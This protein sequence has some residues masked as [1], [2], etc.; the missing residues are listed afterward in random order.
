MGIEATGSYSVA[1][2]KT[3]ETGSFLNGLRVIELADELGEYCG[4]VLAGLGADVIKL[5]PLGGEKTRSYGPFYNDEPHPNRSLHFW[6]YNFGKRSIVI[7]LDSGEGTRQFMELAQTADIII[8]TRT[9]DYL[10]RRGIGYDAIRHHNPSLIYARISPFGDDGPWADYQASDLVHLALGG[11][12]MNCGYDPDPLGFYETPPIA[13]QM[14]HSYHIAG[15]LTA[16]QIIAAL[17]Y[18][19]ET[20]R[21]QRLATSVHDAVAK[22]TETD[23]PDWIYCRLPHYRQTCRHSL[24]SASPTIQGVAADS[25]LRPGLS[26]SKDGRWV[27]AYRTY[28]LGGV[29]SFNATV[30][31]LQKFGAEADL[32]EEKYKDPAFV[33]QPATN[34]HIGTIVERLVGRHLFERD[35]WKEGQDVGLPWAPVRRPEEN[36]GEEHWAKRETFMQVD[37]KEVGKTFTQVGA[38][39]V[40]PGL[41]WR[42]GPRAPL[43]GEHTAE[44]LA[45]TDVRKPPTVQTSEKA[46]VFSKLG[47]PFAL[48]GVRIVDLTWML[49]SAG[50]GRF[51]TALG[52]EVIKV[53]HTSRLDGMRMGMG[54]V[55]VGGRAERDGASGPIVAPATANVNRSGSFMEINAG[56]RSFSLNLKHPRGKALLV[57]LIKDADMVVEGFSPGTMDRMG[58][59][60]ERLREINPKI[61]YVQQSGMGQIGTYGRLRSF[62]PTAQAFSGLSDMSGLPEPYPPAGIGYS[63]LDWFGAYQMALAMMAALYRQKQTGKGCWIDSSQAEVGLYLTGTSILEHSANGR[64][65]SRFGNR[66]PYKQAAPHGAYRARGEDRWIAI[67]AFTEEHWWALTKVLERPGWT[68]DPKLATLALRLLNQDYLDALVNQATVA[69]DAFGLM[70]A[71]QR[72]GVPAGVCQTAEDRYERDPQLKHLEWLVELNQSEIGRWPVKEVPVKLSETPAYIGGVLDR[73]GPSYGEDNDYVLRTILGLSQDQIAQL[74]ADGVF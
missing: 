33:L 47:K 22:N 29:A 37:Y 58:L 46:P 61:V 31:L 53:E 57:D 11:V 14:W 69:W 35:L 71:L 64:R 8:D 16:V 17:T 21:G 43:L 41:P 26:R 32:T 45:N 25:A 56:K 70:D 68:A 1:D 59:G 54:N 5:E 7:D 40:A 48:A 19:S 18:R 27:L 74:A 36:V 9:R 44:I 4:K 49:A 30:S 15:E 24:P 73:H 60:Y 55:P 10:D 50:A 6:H 39:W 66:S 38:K 52:A 13:P 67:S 63:Y 28:L 62:G 72:A 34:F 3:H 12:M 42:T 2:D 20:G 23:L 51:F 65:W